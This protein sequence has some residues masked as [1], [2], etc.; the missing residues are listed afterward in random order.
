[1]TDLPATTSDDLILDSDNP[2]KNPITVM[3]GG[4]KGRVVDIKCSPYKRDIFMSVGS[5]QEIRIYSLLQPH[6]PVLTIHQE[7]C[8]VCQ[9]DWSWSRPMA[10][11]SAIQNNTLQLHDLMTSSCQDL[12]AAE[13]PMPH[14]ALT[15]VSFNPRERSLLATGDGHARVH[16]WKLTEEYTS[17]NA[18]AEIAKMERLLLNN[19]D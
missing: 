18:T 10:F 13:K 7:D 19:D 4:H 14:L 17:G 8:G 5:D 15:S 9:V 6:A 11:A 1:M 16:V 3:F 2:P 12:A